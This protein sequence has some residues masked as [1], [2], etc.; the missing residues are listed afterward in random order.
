[1]FDE[2]FHSKILL[3]T[4]TTQGA[5]PQFCLQANLYATKFSSKI[6]SAIIENKD[7]KT[8]KRMELGPLPRL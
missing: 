2:S 3:R 8:V 7:C 5:T 4:L 1:M 6:F